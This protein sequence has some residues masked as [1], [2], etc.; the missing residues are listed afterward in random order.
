MNTSEVSD[1]W[2]EFVYIPLRFLLATTDFSVPYMGI[3]VE[4]KLSHYLTGWAN[5]EV[6]EK[7]I[8]CCGQHG[9]N[10]KEYFLSSPELA[11]G[12]LIIKNHSLILS[13]FKCP[14]LSACCKDMK[15]QCLDTSGPQHCYFVENSTCSYCLN[16]SG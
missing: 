7:M 10:K 8:V 11:A 9:A 12:T 13:F 2:L 15:R 3:F 4:K 16:S 5:L 14:I 6:A 1:N